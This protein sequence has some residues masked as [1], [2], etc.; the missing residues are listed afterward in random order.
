MTVPRLNTA[1]RFNPDS[2]FRPRSVAVIGD[3]HPGRR[4]NLRQ[5]PPGRVPRHRAVGGKRR[6]PVR[7]R[8]TSPSLPGR[9]TASSRRSKRWR[10]AV[11]S[12]RIVPGPAEGLPEAVQRTGVRLLGPH[13]FGLAVPAIGLNA[14]RAH[15]PPPPGRLGAGLAI[16]RPVP[17]G[18]RLGRAERRRLQPCR[19]HRRQRGYRLRPRARLAVPRP[20]HRRH[21][22]GY[23]PHE[24][25]P[26]LPVRR[27]RRRPAA[28][29]G[30]DP[31][32][33]P[34]A[35]RRRRRGRT[36]LRGRL[37][38][39]RRAQ[40]QPLRGSAGRRRNPVPRPP[41]ARRGAGDRHQCHRRRPARRRCRAAR[42]AAARRAAGHASTASST[43]RS[44]PPGNSARR[45]PRSLRH[46]ASAAC[47]WCMRRPA[48]T[49]GAAIAVLDVGRTDHP[50]AAAGLRHGRDHRRAAPRHAGARPASPPSPRRPRRCAASSTWCATAATAPRRANCRRARCWRWHPTA[51]RCAGCSRRCAAAG[52][53]ALFQDEALDVLAAYGIPG[54]PTRAVAQAEDAPDAAVA[55]GLSGRGEAA[56]GGAAARNGRPAALALDLHDAD[57]ARA[58]ARLLVARQARRARP[59][60]TPAC[61]CSA[62]SAR[63]REL[64]VRVADDADLRADH[65]LRPR[66]HAADGTQDLAMDLPPLNLPLAHGADRAHAVSA[67][68]SARRCAISRRRMSRRWPRCWCGSAS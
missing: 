42:R 15:I 13:S 58:A 21:P 31:R 4:P 23:P 9:R 59:S 46:Q 40:R 28:P 25:P 2:L 62:R 64:A 54:V 50:R 33:R 41:G 11:A 5:P 47:W 17:R 6:R 57:E 60:R 38:P 37:A 44:K 26:R 27:P 22:A 10:P 7:E 66:R 67:R 3:Q 36:G 51:T 1:G 63:A 14:T 16:R 52:R 19:R 65:R 48:P 55:A 20:R 68:C 56:P 24:G 35:G 53:L 34:A 45:S 49:D 29:G 12:P 30:G 39:R 8:P 18:D 32:R 43:C 61:W